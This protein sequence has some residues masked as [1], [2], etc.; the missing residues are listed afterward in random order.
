MFSNHSSDKTNKAIKFRY[1]QILLLDVKTMKIKYDDA[2]KHFF[3]FDK[4]MKLLEM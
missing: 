4:I 2:I 1:E 3:S